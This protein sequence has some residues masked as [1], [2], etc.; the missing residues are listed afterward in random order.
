[1]TS[2]MTSDMILDMTSDMLDF[3]LFQLHSAILIHVAEKNMYLMDQVGKFSEIIIF[4]FDL[5][6]K[7]FFL[8]LGY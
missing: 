2:D 8:L 3:G 7:L 1:M 4:N 6:F 5:F